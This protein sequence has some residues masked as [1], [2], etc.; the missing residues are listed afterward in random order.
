MEKTTQL[1]L[2][3]DPDLAHFLM[4]APF[5]GTEMWEILEKHGQVYSHNM[6]WSQIAIQE[7]KAHFAFGD[8]DEE[9]IEHKWHE[10]HYAPVVSRAS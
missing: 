1:A 3:L 10:A 8:L 5:P 2:E 6:D 9:T 4:A 7:D